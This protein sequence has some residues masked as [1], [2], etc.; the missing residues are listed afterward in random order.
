MF[1]LSVFLFQGVSYVVMGI[2]REV[3]FVLD[4]LEKDSEFLTKGIRI[5][6]EI[7]SKN[8]EDVN[9]PRPEINLV[10]A[11]RRFIIMESFTGSEVL[12]LIRG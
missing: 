8:L 10:D 5:I 7:N 3:D 1:K 12:K 9:R 4:E 6:V 11:T 2:Q